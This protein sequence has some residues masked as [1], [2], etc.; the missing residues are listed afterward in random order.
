MLIRLPNRL[1]F[2]TAIVFF[3]AASLI[4]GAVAST[5]DNIGVTAL[6]AVSTNLNGAGITVAQ[7]E[8]SLTDDLKTWEVN[9]PNAY[10]AASI[11]TYTSFGGATNVFPNDL[12]VES[13]HADDVGQAFYGTADGVATNVARVDSSEADFFYTNYIIGAT[14]PDLGDPV[15]NQSFTFG[16]LAVT[17]QEQVDSEYDNY[18]V[19]NQTLFISAANNFVNNTNV[20]APGTSYNC[21]S[22]GAY[23]NFTYYNSIGPTTDNGRCK[24]DIT[25]IAGETSFSTPMVAGAAAVLMQAALRGDAGSDTNSAFDMRTIKALLLNGAV[26]PEGWTNSTASPLDARY[27]AGVLNLLNSYEQLAGGKNGFIDAT[28]VP[29]GG[30]HPPAAA[31][32]NIPGLSG[33]DFNTN[34]SGEFSDTINHY[35]FNLTNN[36]AGAE[37]SAFATLVWNRQQNQSGINNLFLFLYNCANSNLVQCSTSSVDNVQHVY[38]PQLARGRYDLQVWKAGGIPVTNIV[39]AAE[40]YSLAWEFVASPTLAIK[41]SGVNTVVTWP[42]YPAG[43]LVEAA[44]NLILPGWSTNSLPA[45][46]ITNGQNMLVLN[47]TNSAQFFRLRRP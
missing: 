42:L 4:S 47:A 44:T 8:A 24:P 40:T 34:S 25:A 35:Y 5:L 39:S 13:S 43:F 19:Q 28:S 46:T 31:S 38:V 29:I 2:K 7:P 3:L 6:R 17:N 26:K 20:C 9:P 11:F 37:I 16:S 18:S 27:G 10:Q 15:V 1:V 32:G 36:L 21:I 23:C 45:A 12:G 33:W 30:A 14:L 22:V 41:S